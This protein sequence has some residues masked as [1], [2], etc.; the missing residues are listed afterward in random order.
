MRLIEK[1][2]ENEIFNICGD[3]VITIREVAEKII[4][5]PIESYE[6]GESKEYYEVNINKIKKIQ[7]IQSTRAYVD[8][9]IKNKD[10]LGEL[11]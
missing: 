8:C 6:W 2:Y 3:S 10:N 7:S 4:G 5:V 1:N 11:R 9:Y